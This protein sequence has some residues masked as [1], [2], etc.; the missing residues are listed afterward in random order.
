MRFTFFLIVFLCHSALAAPKATKTP[1]TALPK[2]LEDFLGPAPNR[3]EQKFRRPAHELKAAQELLKKDEKK[4]KGEKKHLTQAIAKLQHLLTSEL[5]EHAA[6]ELAMAYREKNDFAKSSSTA[7]KVL[8]E[9]PGSVY[10]DRLRDLVDKNEC[11]QGL[12][13][14]RE[15][16]IRLLQRCLW[17]APWKEWDEL[18][19]EANALYDHLKASKDPLLDSFIAELIQAMPA[20]STIRSRIA[21]EIPDDKLEKLAT[22]ARYRTKM[23]SAAGVKAVYPDQEIFDQAMKLVLKEEWKEAN[24]LFKRFPTDFPQ[25]EHWDRAQFWIA[26]TEAKL[27][28]EEEA[29]KRF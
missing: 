12:A 5:G 22:M 10:A 25:S 13:A 27:G 14:K 28:N 18:E 2:T 21:K 3:F 29:K 20:S 24:S 1:V 19:T 23:P 9:F 7:E 16:A 8:K 6:F 26:R 15:E 4:T 17:R 11:S